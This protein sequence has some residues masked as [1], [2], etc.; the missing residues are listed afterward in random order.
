MRLLMLACLSETVLT[1]GLLYHCVTTVR[2]HVSQMGLTAALRDAIEA[3]LV[4]GPRVF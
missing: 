1:R 2:D 3:G 4:P